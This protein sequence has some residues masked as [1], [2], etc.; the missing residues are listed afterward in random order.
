MSKQQARPIL[1]FGSSQTTRVFRQL[2]QSPREKQTG[3]FSLLSPKSDSGITAGGCE[4]TTDL[5]PDTQGSSAFLFTCGFRE[6]HRSFMATF[7]CQVQ[8]LP[9]CPARFAQH[10]SPIRGIRGCTVLSYTSDFYSYSAELYRR[11]YLSI[12]DHPFR[13]WKVYAQVIAFP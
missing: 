10:G 2:G 5:F 1:P 4:K 7:G 13:K 9:V 12:R 8:G 3:T 6:A 11:S